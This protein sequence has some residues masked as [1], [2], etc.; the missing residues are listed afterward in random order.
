MNEQTGRRWRLA[1][2]SLL[3]VSAGGVLMATQPGAK[4]RL[5]PTGAV[6][7]VP[8]S[9]NNPV[10]G[11]LVGVT[12]DG[13]LVESERRFSLRNDAWTVWREARQDK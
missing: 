11:R 1:F 8:D 9:N 2:F 7:W 6:T 12:I 4:A 5:E 10:E 3:A 13:K